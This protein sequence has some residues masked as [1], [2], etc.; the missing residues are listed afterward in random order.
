MANLTRI[1]VT[2]GRRHLDILISLGTLAL[3]SNCDQPVSSPP[4]TQENQQTPTK[5]VAGRNLKERQ[6]DFLNRIRAADP[7]HRTIERAM[8][9]ERNELG[10]IL[11]RSVQMD[12]VPELMRS[13]LAQMGREFPGQD[14][15]ILAYTPSDPPHKIGSAHLNAQTRDMTYTPGQ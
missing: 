2:M 8:L 7:E 13:I 9:N 4:L 15:T 14:L 10:L 5:A 3:L 11:D 6:A 1:S 12:R